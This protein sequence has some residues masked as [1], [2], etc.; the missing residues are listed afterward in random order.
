MQSF[1]LWNVINLLDGEA[2][3]FFTFLLLLSIAAIATHGWRWLCQSL[4]TKFLARDERIKNAAIQASLL[5]VTGYIWFVTLIQCLDLISDHLF[6]E[7]LSH[8]IRYLF[9]ISAVL[10]MSWFL[11]SL[12]VNVRHVLLDRA[13]K[14]EIALDP[15]KVYGLTKLFSVVIIV[16][17]IL[18]LLEVAG[19]SVTTLVAFGGISGLAVAFASQEIIA[20][21]FGGFMIH[22]NQPF[23]IG[24]LIAL[25]ASN[26]EGYVEE[27]GWYETCLR[28]RD[29]QPIYIPNALFSKAYV[30]NSTR[31]SHRQINERISIRHDDLPHAKAIVEELRSYIQN[32][33]SVDKSQKLLVNIAQVAAC[34]IDLQITCLSNC[35]DEVQFLHFR[36]N[37]LLHTASIIKAHGAEIAIPL[38][39]NFQLDRK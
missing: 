26:I 21:F 16:L 31:R 19:V 25:P 36:D 37:L 11:L 7:S 28:S 30:V 33:P 2:S 29:K 34:S 17:M 24:D 5:P 18:L 13:M 20:N 27:I 15:G 38:L 12:N 14:K 22:V 6:S 4:Q 23:A 39:G 1:F 8:G 9:S 3:W 32:H 10:F 35:V